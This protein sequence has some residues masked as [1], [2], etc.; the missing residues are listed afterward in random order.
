M[1]QR[2][3][4]ALQRERVRQRMVERAQHDEAVR[5]ERERERLRYVVL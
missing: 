2:R 5:L 4:S 3:E 1:K